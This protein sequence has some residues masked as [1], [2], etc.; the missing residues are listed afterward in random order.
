MFHDHDTFSNEWSYLE[1]SRS[2]ASL[3][4]QARRSHGRDL[5]KSW[6]LHF[7]PQLDDEL[8]T[9]GLLPPRNTQKG[10]V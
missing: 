10:E 8:R 9:L 6:I 3:G 7:A 5:W 4:R 1:H 2:W